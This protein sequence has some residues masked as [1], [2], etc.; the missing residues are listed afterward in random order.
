MNSKCFS[1]ACL[2]VGI[3]IVAFVLMLT[4]DMLLFRGNLINTT[5]V[6]VLNMLGWIL[7]MIG[8]VLRA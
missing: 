3:P 4:I 5:T 6:R 1:R 8:S 7:L 2:R